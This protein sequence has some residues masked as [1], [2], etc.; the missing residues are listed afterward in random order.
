MRERVA[1]ADVG[2]GQRR[3]LLT[4][5]A[6]EIDDLGAMYSTREV[7]IQPR[8]RIPRRPARPVPQRQVGKVGRELRRAIA[9]VR[10]NPVP[11]DLERG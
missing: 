1:T 2:L 3:E 11:V 6:R 5:L 9:V 7:R 8:D 10:P 4:A